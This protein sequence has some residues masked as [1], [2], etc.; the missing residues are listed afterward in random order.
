MTFSLLPQSRKAKLA[1]SHDEPWESVTRQLIN[2]FGAALDDGPFEI[3]C[4]KGAI[5]KVHPNP[6]AAAYLTM[7]LPLPYT[8]PNPVR[9]LD[10]S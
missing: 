6:Y 9:I 10:L 3:R 7:S 8:N 1:I 2:R 5:V 4:M